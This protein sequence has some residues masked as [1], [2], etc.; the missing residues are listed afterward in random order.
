MEFLDINLTKDSSLLLH[1][2]HS[3]FTDF[4]KTSKQENSSLF[5][6]ALCREEKMRVEN[7]TKIR[8]W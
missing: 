7:Q 8:V 6:N 4:K 5:M 1:A 2:V 3:L